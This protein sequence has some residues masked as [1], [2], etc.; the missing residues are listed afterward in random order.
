MYVIICVN[1]CDSYCGNEAIICEN[2]LEVFHE[3]EFIDKNEVFHIFKVCEC[4][5]V[6]NFFM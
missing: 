1:Q 4:G 3:L 2:T 6:K 5:D